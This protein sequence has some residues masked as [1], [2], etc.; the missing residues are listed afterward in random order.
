M[1]KQ[2]KAYTTPPKS[3]LL[4]LDAYQMLCTSPGDG[5]E[6]DGSEEV[7]GE[8]SLAPSRK[9]NTDEWPAKGGKSD[10]WK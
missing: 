9:M 2:R 8:E 7:G 5:I 6:I 3:E 4:T 10:M 1:K